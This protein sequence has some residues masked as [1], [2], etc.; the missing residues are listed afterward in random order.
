M[1]E[2]VNLRQTWLLPDTLP[3]GTSTQL[4]PFQYCTSK[5]VNPYELKVIV[6]VGSLGF[7]QLSCNVKTSISPIVWLPLKSTSA[8][9]EKVFA[10]AASFQPGVLRSPLFKVS[11]PQHEPHEEDTEATP[12]LAASARL[13]GDAPVH[14]ST[15]TR[16]LQPSGEALLTTLIFAVVMGEKLNLRQTLLLPVTFP[17]GTVAQVEP[18]QYCTSKPVNPYEPK[19]IDSVGLLGFDQLSCNIKTST[20]LMVLLPLKSTSAQSG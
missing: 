10:G 13:D 6:S 8:Q 14:A 17:L 3:P 19:V 20:S 16:R 1:G 15:S 4:D 18:F 5:P 12:P 7:D 11:A 9:S 2:N